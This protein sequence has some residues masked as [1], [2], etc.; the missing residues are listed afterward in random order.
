MIRWLRGSQFPVSIVFVGSEVYLNLYRRPTYN[1]FIIKR[2]PTKKSG[3]SFQTMLRRLNHKF[4]TIAKWKMFIS[5]I[6]LLPLLFNKFLLKTFVSFRLVSFL[7]RF[8][9]NI[10]V[11]FVA[12]MKHIQGWSSIRKEWLEFQRKGVHREETNAKRGLPFW[13]TRQAPKYK[14][15]PNVNPEIPS[16]LRMHSIFMREVRQ[17]KSEHD[18]PFFPRV[19]PS[20]KRERREVEIKRSGIKRKKKKKKEWYRSTDESGFLAFVI[21]LVEFCFVFFFVLARGEGLWM[22][23]FR[24]A[25]LEPTRRYSSLLY[26]MHRDVMRN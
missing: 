6:Y 14:E 15:I 7:S 18:K 12:L 4:E 8:S 10:F 1:Q 2:L 3:K 5:T 21:A 20:S 17:N 23:G 9:D 16:H 22:C 19:T 26:T 24:T 11:D 25:G 13:K